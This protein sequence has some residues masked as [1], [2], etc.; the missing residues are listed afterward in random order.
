CQNT[1]TRLRPRLNYGHKPSALLKTLALCPTPDGSRLSEPVTAH[2]ASGTKSDGHGQQ[3]YPSPN[4]PNRM[5][6]L[7]KLILCLEAGPH[8]SRGLLVVSRRHLTS[9]SHQHP[10]FAINTPG[11]TA[12]VPLLKDPSVPRRGIPLIV[13]PDRSVGFAQHLALAPPT[14]HRWQAMSSA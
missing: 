8:G 14:L 10:L 4:R 12:P 13:R 9:A 6:A 2:R 3:V 5:R 7:F 11:S 1:S